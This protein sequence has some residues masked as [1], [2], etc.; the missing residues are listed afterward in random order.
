MTRPRAL[1]S[2]AACS[3]MLLLA[4]PGSASANAGDFFYTYT[5]AD[6]KEQRQKEQ[7]PPSRE[8][9][10]IPEATEA[11]PAHSPHNGTDEDAIVYEKVDCEG[12]KFVVAK[13]TGEAGPDVKFRSVLFQ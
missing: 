7:D 13:D 4:T 2:A 8:C 3:L 9:L 6:G 11:H 12:A 10:N 1:V 5:D